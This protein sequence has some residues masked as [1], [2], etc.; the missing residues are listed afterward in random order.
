MS[1]LALTFSYIRLSE[2]FLMA[3]ITLGI[4]NTL[5]PFASLITF[6]RK[7]ILKKLV[8]VMSTK[9]VIGNRGMKSLIKVVSV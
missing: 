6:K 3:Y 2:N 7:N 8:F 4:L 5:R 1:G 9:K